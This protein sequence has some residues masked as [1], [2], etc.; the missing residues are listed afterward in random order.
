MDPAA[1]GYYQ[2]SYG[3]GRYRAARAWAAAGVIE[4]HEDTGEWDYTD[5]YK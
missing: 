2:E 4:F 3:R 1:Q 5:E